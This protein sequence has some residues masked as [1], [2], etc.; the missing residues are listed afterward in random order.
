MTAN[1]GV[2]L[3]PRN[4]I[5]EDTRQAVLDAAALLQ[6]RRRDAAAMLS[7]GEDPGGE[8][9]ARGYEG[10]NRWMF[11]A[12]QGWRELLSVRPAATVAQLR[13]SLPNNRLM[14][15]RGLKMVSVFD[16]DR[17]DHEARLLLTG[18]DDER[19]LFGFA[20]VQMKIVDRSQVLLQGPFE[21]DEPTIMALRGSA[22]LEAAWRYWHAVAASSFPAVSEARELEALTPRQR[23]I[24]AMLAT[25]ARDE[26]IAAT[27]GVS[28]RT[29]RS[30]IAALM[31]SLGVR[32]RFSA[33][34]R[35]R[36]SSGPDE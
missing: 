31:S 21:D 25:D 24:V 23:Q 33:G 10:T 11:E 13:V 27:L 3:G 28:V 30:D 36:L 19:Y 32:S 9:V 4:R 7:R 1:V 20:T 34:L 6:L 22:C 26:V 14:L 2:G 29:V 15:D 5:A 35:L 8:I 12:A 18:E 16:Y 17:L